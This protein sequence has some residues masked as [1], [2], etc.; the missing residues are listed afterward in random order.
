MWKQIAGKPYSGE[1]YTGWIDAW[2][3][4][5]ADSEGKPL[6]GKTSDY[7]DLAGKTDIEI[8]HMLGAEVLI[9]GEILRFNKNTCVVMVY[10]VNKNGKSQILAYLKAEMDF[11]PCMEAMVKECLSGVSPKNLISDIGLYVD[12]IAVASAAGHDYQTVVDGCLRKNPK[13]MHTLF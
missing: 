5:I 1:R 6:A 8:L 12:T 11:D 7:G 9:T 3:A 10:A 2:V 4:S 13:S